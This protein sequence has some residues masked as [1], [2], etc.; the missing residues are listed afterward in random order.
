MLLKLNCFQKNQD[1]TQEEDLSETNPEDMAMV[2]KNHNNLEIHLPDAIDW[3]LEPVMWQNF[4]SKFCQK[5]SEDQQINHL[6]LLHFMKTFEFRKHQIFNRISLPKLTN[7][8]KCG[9][10]AI[11]A[12][13]LAPGVFK[14][15]YGAHGVELIALDYNSDTEQ[16]IGRKVTGDPNVPYQK[17]TF[18]AEL[19]E[20]IQ[21][22]SNEE[23]V[24]LDLLQDADG[25]CL[26]DKPDAFE[27]L[28]QWQPF[29]LPQGC[30]P[31]IPTTN[32]ERCMA[33]FKAEG[34]IAQD[35]YT[36]PQFIPG[37]FVAFSKNLFGFFFFY[38][39]S[40]SLYYRVKE[41]ISAVMLQNAQP[42]ATIEVQ[43]D[44]DQEELA[45]FFGDN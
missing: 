25:I 44:Q 40:F 6:S 8:P 17:I 27:I 33:R 42:G 15:C 24:Q 10:A 39:R 35:D 45:D 5:R 9:L 7:K 11:M 31:R 2:D 23:Q 21:F 1:N 43:V 19:K 14:A 20:F 38:L 16:I 26:S 32:V 36:N 41:D 3:T 12:D 28:S 30:Y 18:R 29:H 22:S 37:Q 13:I 34:Q 4:L